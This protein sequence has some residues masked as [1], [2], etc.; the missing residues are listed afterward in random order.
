VPLDR[1]RD[2][3]RLHQGPKT[4]T[5]FE[6]P[7]LLPSVLWPAAG[8][9]LSAAKLRQF[10]RAFLG[11]RKIDTEGYVSTHQHRGQ[12]HDDGWPFPS[13]VQAGGAGWL[14]SHAGNPFAGM[15]NLP[16]LT[17]LA[18]WESNAVTITAHDPNAGL[19]LALGSHASLTSP[20]DERRFIRHP[21]H[22]VSLERNLATRCQTLPRMDHRHRTRIP[23]SPADRIQSAARAACL[24][25]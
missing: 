12:A 9:Q 11:E 6:T 2:L 8:T 1:L 7:Y 22:R 23:G 4:T 20:G 14:F 5:T 21:I 17:S 19:Q 16:L 18:G 3:F 13:Y 15:F 10:Y 24:W 25:S